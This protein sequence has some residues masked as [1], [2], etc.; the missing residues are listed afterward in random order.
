MVPPDRGKGGG[1]ERQAGRFAQGKIAVLY[2]EIF[3]DIRA[4]HNQN[5]FFPNSLCHVTWEILESP[6]L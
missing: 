4:P 2:Y 1:E 5:F 3:T 6:L